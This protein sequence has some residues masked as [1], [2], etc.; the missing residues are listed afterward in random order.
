VVINSILPSDGLT[1]T[2]SAAIFETTVSVSPAQMSAKYSVSVPPS[3]RP[4]SPWLIPTRAE[5]G[6]LKV[7][8]DSP[9]N[10]HR[11]P[12][13]RRRRRQVAV[14]GRLRG[15]DV[16]IDAIG[17]A[18]AARERA[19][20]G[21]R[22]LRGPGRRLAPDLGAHLVGQREF[23]GHRGGLLCGRRYNGHRRGWQRRR[24]ATVVDLGCR[25]GRGA[26]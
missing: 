4:L 3:S 24:A 26:R 16:E 1:R 18:D 15:L 6:A 10:E 14:A 20:A 7:L 12:E 8:S 11:R 19:H 2:S 23:L 25:R 21:G 5:R 13:I 22:H 17:V 9:G